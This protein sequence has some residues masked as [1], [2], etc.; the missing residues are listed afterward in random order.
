M[1]RIAAGDRLAAQELIDELGDK[2]RD[3]KF[4]PGTMTVL[5]G[6]SVTIRVR[7]GPPDGV[8]LPV[9]RDDRG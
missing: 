6:Q 7:S 3:K 1:A 2:A 9:S 4:D 8:D 5:P